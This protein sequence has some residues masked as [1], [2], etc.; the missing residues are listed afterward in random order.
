VQDEISN[1]VVKPAEKGNML[2]RILE[3][4]RKTLP[5]S[6]ERQPQFFTPDGKENSVSAF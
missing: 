2:D 1:E 4:V 6:L 3:A 5:H